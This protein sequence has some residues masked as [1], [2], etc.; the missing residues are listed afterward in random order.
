MNRDK[1]FARMSGNFLTEHLPDDWSSWSDEKLKK[2]FSDYTWHPFE[3]W[4]FEEV[5]DLIELATRDVMELLR[6]SHDG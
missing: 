1:V 2:F 5:F 3:H 6:E 4:A